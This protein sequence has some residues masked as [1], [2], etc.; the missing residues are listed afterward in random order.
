MPEP[1]LKGVLA[2]E[3]D[4]RLSIAESVCF[5]AVAVT[6][7]RVAHVAWLD[8]LLHSIQGTS[9][10]LLSSG[11]SPQQVVHSLLRLGLLV[12]VDPGSPSVDASAGRLASAVDKLFEPGSPRCLVRVNPWL[13]HLEPVL[14]PEWFP[15][16]EAAMGEAVMQCASRLSSRE[17]DATTSR[18]GAIEPVLRAMQS[19][20]VEYAIRKQTA[21][22]NPQAGAAMVT[23]A[24][25]PAESDSAPGL[26]GNAAAQLLYSCTEGAE[27]LG[28]AARCVA[29][30]ERELGS[31]AQARRLLP[32]PYAGPILFRWAN[33]L[34]ELGRDREA[35]RPLALAREIAR[36]AGNRPRNITVCDEA[37][38]GISSRIGKPKASIA[39]M[40]RLAR[41]LREAPEPDESA[42]GRWDLLRSL[43]LYRL[44]CDQEAREIWH[45]LIRAESDTET[46]GASAAVACLHL[47]RS[48]LADSQAADGKAMLERGLALSESL[49]GDAAINREVFLRPLASA[50]LELD[51]TEQALATFQEA[52]VAHA[53]A[54]DSTEG[55]RL[56]YRCV[57]AAF[58]A[59]TGNVDRAHS[60][61]LDA[62]DQLLALKPVPGTLVSAA[63]GQFVGFLIRRGM[64]SQAQ[65]A[66]M[67]A[68]EL[69]G[70]R[71]VTV[72]DGESPEMLRLAITHQQA[73]I[74]QSSG[75]T[76]GAIR[77]W[78]QI[79]MRLERL[80]PRYH[81]D[82]LAVERFLADAQASPD[83][84]DDHGGDEFEPD[85]DRDGG[86][87]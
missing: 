50:L 55:E 18:A 24:A 26:L 19:V 30:L 68:L 64:Q 4:R 82:R 51:L 20:M 15:H 67:A 12:A 25:E 65:D 10:W 1:P 61:F 36:R 44:D 40:S 28:G 38:A 22:S 39:I 17:A 43:M 9:Q 80:G 46:S 78:R 77:L 86:L 56:E 63:V 42:A 85:G 87:M 27:W 75:D 76:D 35:I 32:P 52:L 54:P 6:P 29:F 69:L 70:E 45:A 5:V 14:L 79:S 3:L 2:T 84:P 57:R 41:Q 73:F 13:H 7:G 16:I 8:E 34:A 66:V 21:D 58:V 81:P 49:A 33:S 53:A 60:E 72:A 62:F 31:V 74:D 59:A 37:L 83:T 48:L 47:G 11:R 23:S 71:R